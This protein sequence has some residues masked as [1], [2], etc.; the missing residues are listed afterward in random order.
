MMRRRVAWLLALPIAAAGLSA[1]HE[2]AWRVAVPDAAVRSRELAQTGNGYAQH[3]PLVLAICLGS[4][5]IAFALRARSAFRGHRCLDVPSK[6]LAL[7]P[8]LAFLLREEIERIGHSGGLF[9]GVF[10]D[11]T[12]LIGLAVQIPLG[13]LVLLVTRALDE[14]ATS[15]GRVLAGGPMRRLVRALELAFPRPGATAPRIP[16][17]ARGYGERGPPSRR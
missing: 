16:V 11:R 5:L 9:P 7:L 1:G 2:L 3:L 13:L 14:L 10:T 4:V 12:F 6:A 17:L 15:V 8:P